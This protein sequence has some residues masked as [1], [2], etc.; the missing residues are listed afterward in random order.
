MIT[1]NN[2]ELMW[3]IKRTIT[4][5]NVTTSITMQYVP[6]VT[7]GSIEILVDQFFRVSGALSSWLGLPQ[8]HS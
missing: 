2:R 5:I 3:E 4:F 6:F 7:I 8:I 1:F